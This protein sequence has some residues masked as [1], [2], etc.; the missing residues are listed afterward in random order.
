M[1]SIHIVGI[2][3]SPRDQATEAV[4]EEALKQAR[5]FK[6]VTTDQIN[7]RE[8]KFG[9]CLHC[10]KCYEPGF[11]EE[12]KHRCVQNDDLEKIYPRMLK[13]DGFILATPVY[14]GNP[15]GMLMSFMNRL[16]PIN[17]FLGNQNKTM[18]F[19]VIG[20]S[21][22]CGM[23]TAQMALMRTVMHGRYF[24][25]PSRQME[26][27]GVQVVSRNPSDQELSSGR[28]GALRDK[29]G[30]K[31]VSEMV[32]TMVNKTR[33]IKAGEKALGIKH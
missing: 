16:R 13:A 23:D 2:N 20:G 7:L 10:D 25:I 4:L 6:N 3:G 27:I 24:Y 31:A 8:L 17:K 26:C 28:F 21:K 9:F 15:S 30:M 29:I 14:G 19:I 11:Y 18:Q 32:E 12:N 22:R 33:L 1:F 5:S